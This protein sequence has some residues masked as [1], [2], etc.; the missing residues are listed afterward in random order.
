MAIEKL[1]SYTRGFVEAECSG[2]NAAVLFDRALKSGVELRGLRELGENRFYFSVDPEDYKELRRLCR[3]TGCRVRVQKKR[4][5]RFRVAASKKALPLAA[6]LAA[7]FLTLHLL[8]M[9][10]AVIEIDGKS[11]LSREQIDK[12]LESCGIYEYAFSRSVDAKAAARRMLIDNEQLSWCAVNIFYGRAQIVL[13]DKIADPDDK[14]GTQWYIAAKRDAQIKHIALQSG[15]PLVRVGDTVAKGQPLVVW[16]ES[17]FDNSWTRNISAEITGYTVHDARF[18]IKKN[19]VT[20][21]RSGEFVESAA[22]L[23]AGQPLLP[24]FGR[25]PYRY[26]DTLVYEQSVKLFGVPLPLAVQ[27]TRFYEVNQSSVFL[28]KERAQA[29]LEQ[30]MDAYER[31][32]FPKAR[33]LSKDSEFR[34]EGNGFSLTV[35]YHCE[36]NVGEY[37]C[38]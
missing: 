32:Q 28:T 21:A 11:T 1:L 16:D 38:P 23:V 27:R 18:F 29:L 12:S 15:T 22:L 19:H 24:S 34:D 7:F 4:G 13:K 37:I 35:S 14:S 10:T 25:S 33:V 26:F 17:G 8:G 30:Q 5:V 36:E 3:G 6:G 2:K 20:R 31:S 9:L